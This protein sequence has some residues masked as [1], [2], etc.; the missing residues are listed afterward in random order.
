[1]LGLQH[2]LLCLSFHGGFVSSEHQCWILLH[3]ETPHLLLLVVLA[4]LQE[5]LGLDWAQC[6]VEK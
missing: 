4:V 5:I 3:L 6:S 2:H 1:M